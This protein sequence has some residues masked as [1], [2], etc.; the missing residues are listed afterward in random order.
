MVMAGEGVL[1]GRVQGRLWRL[2]GAGLLFGV[3]GLAAMA[4][5]DAGGRLEVLYAGS[6][7]GVMEH[8][9]G[10]AFDAATGYHFEGYAGG[11]NALAEQIKGRLRPADV[12]IS[13]VPSVNSRLMGKKNGNWLSHYVRFAQSPL[14]IGYNPKSP[15]AQDFRTKPWLVALQ[16]PGLRIGRTDPRLDP[17]GRLTLS[18]LA[19][20]ARAEHRPHLVSKIFGSPENP[21]QVLPE[22]ELVGRLQSG[23]ID[24]GFFYSLETAEAHIPAV[25]LPAA[26][27]PHATYTVAV[28]NRAPHAQAARAFVRFLLGPQGRRLLK[29]NGLEVMIARHPAKMARPMP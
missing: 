5:A 11:S 12:F 15:F 8:S 7:V 29:A 14:V 20:V 27:T 3:M 19:R 4:P 6:L 26:L 25:A 24:A 18:L 23:Q 22:E 21:A 1:M 9:V 13:A 16:E 10:P 28:L 2:L 17:K